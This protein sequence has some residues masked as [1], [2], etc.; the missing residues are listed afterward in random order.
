M[1]VLV[2]FLV[3]FLVGS[4]SEGARDVPASEDV[5]TPQLFW[6]GWPWGGFRGLGHLGGLG[7]LL[8]MGSPHGG[9]GYRFDPKFNLIID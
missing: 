3:T 9:M 1:L 6:G 5:Y 2:S 7:A 8:G 4:G